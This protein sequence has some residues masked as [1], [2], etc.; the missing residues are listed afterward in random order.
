MLNDRPTSSV[1][2]ATAIPLRTYVLLAA[3]IVTMQALALL[4]MGQPPICECG[5]VSLWQGAVS[6]PENS[7]QLSDWYTYSHVIHGFGFYLLLWLVAPRSPVGMRFVAA[8][9][10]EAGWELFENTPFIINRYRES[11]LA[12]G[13]F[14]D[15]IV[16]S[17]SDSLAA[18]LGF[19]MARKLPDWII[20]ALVVAME[21]LA[22][23]MIRDNLTLNILQLIAP[24]EAISRWQF[25]G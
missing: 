16:N 15:S 24:S 8:V 14:G 25:G 11:A 9:A 19:L 6:S 2:L 3:A 10:L 1:T 7:Q 12:Q 23:F 21:L 4:A 20:L 18:A 13:Y 17:V 5:Y 22:L